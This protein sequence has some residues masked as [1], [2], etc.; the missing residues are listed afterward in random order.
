MKK[1]DNCKSCANWSETGERI[2]DIKGNKIRF[3]PCRSP[4]VDGLRK[5]EQTVDTR[6]MAMSKA[7][8]PLLTHAKFS[9]NLHTKKK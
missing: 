1:A 5:K 8:H 4:Q 7:I 6:V 9:C 2:V 3:R